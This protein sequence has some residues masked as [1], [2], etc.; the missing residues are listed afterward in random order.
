MLAASA[1]RGREQ[2]R[3]PGRRR[4]A[5]RNER[6][7]A[8]KRD[9]DRQ[10]RQPAHAGTNALIPAHAGVQE[11]LAPR[12][13]GDERIIS[14]RSQWHVLRPHLSFSVVLRCERAQRASLEG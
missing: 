10:P 1:S 6:P 8:L 11:S 4:A 9:K 14:W 7:L 5:A 12:F 2:F 13:R 3:L